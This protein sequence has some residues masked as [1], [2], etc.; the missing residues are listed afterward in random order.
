MSLLYLLLAPLAFM[1]QKISL[2]PDTILL[3]R[4][5]SGV[6]EVRHQLGERSQ[7][8][9]NTP[10]GNYRNTRQVRIF[11]PGKYHVTVKTPD[12]SVTHR[13]S[14]FVKV[15]NRPVRVLQDSV[16]CAGREMVLDAGNPGMRYL[17]NTGEKSRKIVVRKEGTYSVRISNEKCVLYDTAKVTLTGISN[18]LGAKE[19][20]FCLNESP[21]VLA[22]KGGRDVQVKWSTGA[23]TSSINVAG[24]GMYAVVVTHPV[25][26]EVRDS[27]RVKLKAC[28][29][30]VIVPNRF[31]PNED[32]RNDYFF[33]VLNCEY[34]YY[35]LT[36]T[37]RWG[38]TVYE[39]LDAQGKWDGRFKG[40][41]CP[42]DIYAYTLE[43]T[44][45]G[46][47]KKDVREGTVALIR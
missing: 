46:T 18:P 32:N 34:S 8:W 40:N 39:T 19:A 45:K 41:L 17:W 47:G 7:I 10:A 38:Y 20:Q 29:C 5:D 28:G 14:A 42:E 6:I 27:V 35:R 21:R 26:G 4:G 22:V 25:C 1:A 30:E 16:L 44:E 33:P 43:T 37:D 36:I 3:C 24:E 11:A 23:L 15:L 31:T 12:G 13:D 9:W 2:L